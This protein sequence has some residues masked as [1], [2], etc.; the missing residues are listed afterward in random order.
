MAHVAPWK[1]SQVKDLMQI[2][3]D[4][5]V[6][7]LINIKG[8]PGPQIQKMRQKLHDKAVIKIAKN[9][10][11][12]MALENMEEKKEGLIEMVSTLDGQMGI[13]GT[14]MNPFK[15]FQELEKSKAPAPVKGGETAPEDIEINAGDTG[16][17]PGPIVG[18]L[19][20]VGIPAAIEEGKV[21]IKADKL[22]VKAGDIISRDIATMLTRL[23]IYPLTVGLDLRA[24][25]EEGIIFKKKD[26]DVD[27]QQFIDNMVMGSSQAFNL[28]VN[29]NYVNSITILPLIQTAQARAMNLVY[30]SNIITPSSIEFLLGKGSGQMLSLTSH[31]SPE[32]LDDELKE[33]LGDVTA[34][35]ATEAEATADT[36]DDSGKDKKVDKKD[37]KE[38]K[39]EKVSEEDAAAGLG[40]LFD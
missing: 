2:I 33:R 13:I 34:S 19:Q 30:N 15:L 6:V 21:V 24:V 7:G 3:S 14:N 27:P 12:L 29:I 36:A 39:E 11:L 17:K 16:F 32:A 35:A 31:L 18:E 8:I 25:F 22:L 4:K 20:R 26:L 1:E 37:K 38:K 5:P 9:K 23:E 40:A 28:A 10:L